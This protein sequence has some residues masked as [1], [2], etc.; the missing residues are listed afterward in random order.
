MP[1]IKNIKQTMS[2]QEI[3]DE[4]MAQ[5][6]FSESKGNQ[7]EPIL[8]LIDKMDRL[9]TTE[10]R[11]SVMQEQGCCKG[12][13]RD[14][15]CKEFAKLHSKKSIAEKLS[16]ISKEDLMMTPKLNDD[17]TFAVTME[18]FKNGVHNGKSTCS[19]GMIKK[20]KQPFSVSP[21]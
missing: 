16:L 3:P 14:K 5:F 10:Q 17:G 2:E 12:G 1:S 20:L 6:D 9:L 13:K 21:T 8:A 4:I 18:G 19:C 11:L 15:N 7:P